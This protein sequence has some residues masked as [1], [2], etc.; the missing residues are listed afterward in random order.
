V[1]HDWGDVRDGNKPLLTKPSI[2][3]EY[4]ILIDCHLDS[5]TSSNL[6]LSV[7][8]PRA[9]KEVFGAIGLMDAMSLRD[10]LDELIEA[11]QKNEAVRTEE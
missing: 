11:A 8:K 9:S 10:R 7:V 2:G 3:P 6:Y 1:T 4:A 5:P